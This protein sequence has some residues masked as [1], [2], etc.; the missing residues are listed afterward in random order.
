MKPHYWVIQ[1]LKDQRVDLARCV[2]AKVRRTVDSHPIP[3]PYVQGLKHRSVCRVSADQI[4]ALL[5]R[6]KRTILSDADPDE[7]V[8]ATH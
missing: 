6:K 1:G 4:S 8:R 2:E 5:Q 7:L 3:A